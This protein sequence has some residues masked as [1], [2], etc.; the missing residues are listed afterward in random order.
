MRAGHRL[1]SVKYYDAQKEEN[2][3]TTRKTQAL[4]P[5]HAW[6]RVTLSTS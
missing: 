1:P 3:P 4:T 6:K 2:T 5:A